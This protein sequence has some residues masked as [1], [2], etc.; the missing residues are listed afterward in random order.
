MLPMA[1][2]VKS[3]QF[4]QVVQFITY[5]AGCLLPGQV[6]PPPTMYFK[7]PWSQSSVCL[8]LPLT[9]PELILNMYQGLLHHQVLQASLN[10]DRD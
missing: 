10:K 9:L 1:W 3:E 2:V 7:G 6:F 5:P 4:P 8:Y